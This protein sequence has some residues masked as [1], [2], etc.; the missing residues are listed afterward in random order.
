MSKNDRKTTEQAKTAPRFDKAIYMIRHGESVSN[1]KGIFQGSADALTDRGRAQALALGKRLAKHY[2][3]ERIITS[4]HERAKETAAIIG[5]KL[6]L[7]P[8]ATPLLI[9]RRQPSTIIGRTT[10]DAEAVSIHQEGRERFHDPDFLYGDGET[11]ADLK[12]RAL[13]A[14]AHILTQPEKHIAV[15]T[16]GVFATFLAAASQRGSA[17]TSHDLDTYQFRV[18]NTGLSIL[19]HKTRHTFSG[20]DRGWIILRWNDIAHLEGKPRLN[21]KYTL[22][23]D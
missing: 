22:T 12:A 21:S 15:V 8:S 5:G 19:S 4:T 23:Q 6:C 17:L 18:A 13:A 20:D 2:P 7:A 9:E 14:L 11:F 10:D 1:V 3:I 16:H